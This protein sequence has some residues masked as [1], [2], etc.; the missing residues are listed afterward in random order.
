M[1]LAIR[2]LLAERTSR[3]PGR[4]KAFVFA[5]SVLVHGGLVAAFLLAPLLWAD[6]NEFP[7]Y[8]A[9]QIVPAQ[10]LGTSAPEPS[11]P[12]PEPEP[13]Q[14]PPEPEASSP[15]PERPAPVVEEPRAKPAPPK[16]APKRVETRPT[17]REGSARGS[18]LGT[19]NFGTAVAGFDNPDFTYDYYVDQ[20]L[21]KIRQYWVRPPIGG[22]VE[23]TVRYR[24]LKDGRVVDVRVLNSS[25]YNSFDLAAMRAIQSASPLPP[26]PQSFRHDS[27]GVN[28]VVR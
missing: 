6:D 28:L 9:V 2:D 3:L 20:M 18:S 24:I 17:Q 15:E 23:T 12:E 4:R 21:A 13:V 10:I 26:L 22:A 11:Q 7:E 16:P 27:L 8:V 5:L 19:S 14:A 25:G 1:E